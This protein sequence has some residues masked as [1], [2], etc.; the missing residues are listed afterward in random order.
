MREV[1]EETGIE[2]KVISLL[3]FRQAHGD[4][5]HLFSIRNHSSFIQDSILAGNLPST[6]TPNSVVSSDIYLVFHLEPLHLDINIQE[7]EIADCKWMDG[8]PHLSFSTS[9]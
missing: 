3:C 6:L 7:S 5:P 4:L 1:L 2:T 9:K 8:T